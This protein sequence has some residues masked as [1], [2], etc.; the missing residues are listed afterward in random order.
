MNIV[1]RVVWA[2]ALCWTYSFT[3]GVLFAVCT[4]ERRSFSSILLPGVLPVVLL[5]STVV[6]ICITP[7]AAWSLRTGIKNVCVFGPIL[8][9]VLAGYEVLVIPRTGIY[10]PYGL[11]IMAILGLIILGFIPPS[12]VGNG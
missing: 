3:L 1:S 5:G 10:G 4:S 2:A 11:I 9:I 8:W 6:A 7:V 12:R